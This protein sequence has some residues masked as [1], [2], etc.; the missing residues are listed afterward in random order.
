MERS[1]KLTTIT[2]EDWKKS[3]AMG[4]NEPNLVRLSIMKS[5]ELLC[6]AHRYLYYVKMNPVI[7]DQKYDLIEKE[8]LK[9]VSR[10]SLLHKPGSDLEQ[11]YPKEAIE[12]AEKL[13]A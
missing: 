12:L 6:L 10:D 13:A 8:A 3:I 1:S 5:I 11:D 2:G 7:S 4:R 9:S